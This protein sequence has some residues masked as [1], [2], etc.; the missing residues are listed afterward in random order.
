MRKLLTIVLSI[1]FLAS[2]AFSN[3]LGFASFVLDGN[4][5]IKVVN[6]PVPS[7]TITA[8]PNTSG[9]LKLELDGMIMSFPVRIVSAI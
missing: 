5:V 1:I 2:Q 8:S 4:A 6:T 7:T 3:M 9:T